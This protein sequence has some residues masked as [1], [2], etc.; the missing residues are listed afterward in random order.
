MSCSRDSLASPIEPER[1]LWPL[2]AKELE[3]DTLLPAAQRPA[4]DFDLERPELDCGN[5][6]TPSSRIGSTPR[7]GGGKYVP[8]LTNIS[9]LANFD[10]NCGTISSLRL[11]LSPLYC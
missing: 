2:P 10:S 3:R 1:D 11:S 8:S 7:S 9:K 4:E 6:D 5:G